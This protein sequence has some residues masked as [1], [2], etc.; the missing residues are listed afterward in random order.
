MRGFSSADPPA[1]NELAYIKMLNLWEKG[2][3]VLNWDCIYSHLGI[4]EAKS[5]EN[6]Y[7]FTWKSQVLLTIW[8]YL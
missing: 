8:I 3:Y 4:A 5:I 7:L 2:G 1:Y 6:I